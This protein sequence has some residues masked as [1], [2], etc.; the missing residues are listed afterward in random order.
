MEALCQNTDKLQKSTITDYI[1]LG[2]LLGESI[3]RYKRIRL[4]IESSETTKYKFFINETDAD[5]RDNTEKLVKRDR[6]RNDINISIRKN[7]SYERS[8]RIH[9][10]NIVNETINDLI[11]EY[12]NHHVDFSDGTNTNFDDNIL[13]DIEHK[14]SRC[15]NCHTAPATD[16]IMRVTSIQKF[17]KRKNI[18]NNSARTSTYLVLV[19]DSK[20]NTFNNSTVTF[21]YKF[22]TG[23]LSYERL[24]PNL[25]KVRKPQARYVPF[26]NPYSL[27][28]NAEYKNSKRLKMLHSDK[29]LINRQSLN[30]KKS[31]VNIV[32]YYITISIII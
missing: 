12:N 8:A 2:K 10:R 17:E 13:N 25:N 28:L 14:S 4:L 11:K 15:T 18:K 32:K 21:R 20:I 23:M 6:A 9:K 7:I 1:N 19:E 31:R 22:P 27:G 16:E 5:M 24:N 30:T 3:S 29:S 26:H